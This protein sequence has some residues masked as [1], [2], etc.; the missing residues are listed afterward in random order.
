MILRDAISVSLDNLRQSRLRTSLTALGV[1]IGIGSIVGMLAIAVGL[2]D[3]LYAKLLTTGFFR[4][5]MVYA[6]F[7]QGQQTPRQLDDAAAVAIRQIPGVKSTARETRVPAVLELD[8]KQTPQVG[9]VGVTVDDADEA[10]FAEIRLGSFFHAEEAREIILNNQTAEALGFK[11]PGQIVGRSVRVLVRV[12]L[13]QRM[14]PMAGFTPP[15]FPMPEPFELRVVGV[16]E[17]ERAI[18][19]DMGSRM[20]YVPQKVA[21]QQ[22]EFFQKTSP[23]LAG[24]A[25]AAQPLQVHLNDARDVDRVEKEIRGLGFRTV[26]ISSIISNLRRVFVVVDMLLTLIGSMALA[27]AS[28]GIIN[29]MVMAVLERTRE[30]GVMKAV[31]AEDGDIRHIFLTESAIIGGMGGLAGLLLAWMLGRTINWGANI[32]LVRQGFRAEVLFHIPLWLIASA[33][34]F[35]LLVSIASGLYPAGRAARIDPTRALRHD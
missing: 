28:L 33:L 20:V 15:A 30:I 19:T 14:R 25:M 32:Y 18:F 8:G 7:G 21:E 26:S 2:Q 9:L 11:D 13:A 22:M 24:M 34:G 1:A 12:P 4:R 31:G 6:A 23:M 35:A 10:V 27:V 5:I 17:R 16:I 29:T 3:N